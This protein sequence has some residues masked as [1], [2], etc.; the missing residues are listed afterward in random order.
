MAAGPLM[1]AAA[2]H[3]AATCCA[4]VTAASAAVCRG[5]ERLHIPCEPCSNWLVRG[6]L[7]CISHHAS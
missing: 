4:V 6:H 1:L 7:A 2:D 3:H 5:G